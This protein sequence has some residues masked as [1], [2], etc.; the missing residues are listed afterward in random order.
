MKTDEIFVLIFIALSIVSVAVFAIHS[1]RQAAANMEVPGVD[2]TAPPPALN[3][4][5]DRQASGRRRRR[6]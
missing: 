1:R 5:R 2:S 6:R 4:D 3:P